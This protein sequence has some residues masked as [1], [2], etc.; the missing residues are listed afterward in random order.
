MFKLSFISFI[1]NW[2]KREGLVYL[3]VLFWI[4]VGGLGAYKQ[5]DFKDLAVYLGP[6]IIYITTYIW[7]E[8]H[9]PSTKT[10]IFK[11]GLSS[12]R[13]VMI[14]IILLLW[15]LIGLLSIEFKINLIDSSIYF[16]SLSG[17]ITSWIVG[18]VYKSQD[19]IKIKE[20]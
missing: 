5:V 19:I 10:G 13:E 15:G 8:S 20:I 4:I 1:K 18:E 3:V 9:K 16:I 11:P 17:F 14:Y 2:G 6:L 7:A 12:R